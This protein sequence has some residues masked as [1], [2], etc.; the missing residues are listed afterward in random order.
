MRH[1]RS[2]AD[3]REA[4]MKPT[5]KVRA[6]NLYG[7]PKEV[8]Q[9]GYEF[10]W[11]T[12]A[13]SSVF[14]Y[15]ALNPKLQTLTPK[16]R[17]NFLVESTPPTRVNTRVQNRSLL[18]HF[19]AMLANMGTN[20]FEAL[21]VMRARTI[22]SGNDFYY[23]NAFILLVGRICVSNFHCQKIKRRKKGFTG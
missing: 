4:E 3:C 20:S 2:T 5:R 18:V 13:M 7:A 16:P 19:L 15:A 23:I 22:S 9:I 12:E 6:R 1:F 14:M 17:C 11:I 10:C 8:P 21:Y